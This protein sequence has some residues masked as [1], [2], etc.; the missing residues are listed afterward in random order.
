MGPERFAGHLSKIVLIVIAEYAVLVAL[1]FAA[2]RLLAPTAAQ[3]ASGAALLFGVLSIFNLLIARRFLG[4]NLPPRA[5]KHLSQL[6]SEFLY[7]RWYFDEILETMSSAVLVLDPLLTV[8]SMN[9]AGRDLLSLREKEELVGRPFRFHPLAKEVY[10]G[11]IYD[12]RGKP[13]EKVFEACVREGD[14]VLLEKVRYQK[15]EDTAAVDLDILVYPWKNREDNTERLVIRFDEHRAN[16]SA[17]PGPDL[18]GLLKA[19][20][21]LSPP[22]SGPSPSPALQEDLSAIRDHLEALLS[23]S[24]SIA[25]V[26]EP[27]ENGPR[28]ELLLFEM[29]VKRILHMMKGMEEEIGRSFPGK[30]REGPARRERDG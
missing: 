4:G 1:F 7:L 20:A 3:V 2:L 26:L 30:G 19:A 29:Q 23:S 15:R 25:S 24:Q 12:F 11:E 8:R 18:E 22:P 14:P 17:P 5:E 10:S 16:G 6:R 13:L 27:D 28:A 9:H 21:A